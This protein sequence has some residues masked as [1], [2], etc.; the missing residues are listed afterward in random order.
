MM[1]MTPRLADGA[2]LIAGYGTEGFTI[3]GRTHT[4][5]VLVLP[6][7]VRPWPDAALTEE[8]LAKLLA[9][10][11]PEILLIGTGAAHI[12]MPPALRAALKHRLGCSIETM[13]TGA[14]CRTFNILLAEGRSVAAALV[15]L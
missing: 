3:A 7:S 12:F 4:G 13:D 9:S 15:S 1:D 5:S 14:A 11:S 10:E 6:M 2:S 8:G